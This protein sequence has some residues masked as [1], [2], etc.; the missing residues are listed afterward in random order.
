MAVGEGLNANCDKGKA[1]AE[2]ARKTA[3]VRF[4]WRCAGSAS[5]AARFESG[6]AL[7]DG[8][9]LL[10]E[11]AGHRLGHDEQSGCI[12]TLLADEIFQPLKALPDLL[13]TSIRLSSKGCQVALK[14]LQD[15][16]HRRLAQ[17]ENVA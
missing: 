11:I 9:D 8:S 3:A 16:I 12:A 10:R 17:G 5:A 1:K 2:K 15:L 13:E 14:L 7:L 6:D 4:E